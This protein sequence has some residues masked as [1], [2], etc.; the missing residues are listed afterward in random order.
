MQVDKYPKLTPFNWWWEANIGKFPF[1]S[2]RSPLRQ[3]FQ[4]T[5]YP[6]GT[7]TC[8][9]IGT[10]YWDR[11]KRNIAYSLT[12]SQHPWKPRM[13]LF[14]SS[15]ALMISIAKLGL[16][17]EESGPNAAFN[18]KILSTKIDWIAILLRIPGNQECAYF[19]PIMTWRFDGKL[20]YEGCGVRATCSIELHI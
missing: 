13:N 8:G 18:Y 6:R 5:N 10:N 7:R 4:E 2:S 12:H 15:H 11:S 3:I 17:D 9:N 20:A 19:L 14:P 16:R 1:P